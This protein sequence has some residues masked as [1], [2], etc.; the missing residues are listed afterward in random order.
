MYKA[1]FVGWG[2]AR[3]NARKTD[4]SLKCKNGDGTF[5]LLFFFWAEITGKLAWLFGRVGTSLKAH[6]SRDF[7]EQETV[8]NAELKDGEKL[9]ELSNG[10][11][12]SVREG[13]ERASAGVIVVAEVWRLHRVGEKARQVSQCVC[14][15]RGRGWEWWVDGFRCWDKWR[16]VEDDFS[17]SVFYTVE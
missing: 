2:R 3:W 4:S 7:T 1:I 11:D 15:W 10:S 13:S 17:S 9:G 5:F 6:S 12:V 16:G 14:V 8:S